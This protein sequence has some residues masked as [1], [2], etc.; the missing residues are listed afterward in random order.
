MDLNE[1]FRKGLI[2]KTRIDKDL[3]KSLIEMSSIKET[4]VK[5][6]SINDINISA[7]VS[8]A[9][10]SLRELLEAFCVM[11]GYK[12]ISHICIGELLRKEIDEFDYEQFD[13]VR[14]IR[15][16][17]NYY[18]KKVEFGQGKEIIEKI[19]TIRN[20][21]KEKHLERT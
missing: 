17:I 15:N 12:V 13:R 5:T 21:I 3:V 14:W 7:Y 9:Y 8:L 10:D 11:K 2:K 19:F 16:S 6:A 4:T 1:C 18:G 20:K